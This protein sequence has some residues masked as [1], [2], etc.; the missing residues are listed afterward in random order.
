M[1]GE[2]SVSRIILSGLSSRPIRVLSSFCTNSLHSLI[3]GLIVSSLSFDN[4]HLL[5]CYVLFF[6]A[7]IQLVFRALF[8]IAIRKDSVSLLRYSHIYVHFFSCEISFVC[9]LI[10]PYS[11]FSSDF[12]FLAIFVLLIPD[13]SI[14]SGRFNLFSL[15][16]LCSLCVLVSMHQRYIQCRQV[17]LLLFF[18]HV[19]SF[20]VISGI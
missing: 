20:E 9:R 2:I 13:L 19:Q 6:F 5:I 12:Y 10:C 16:F 7:L 1:E 18:L 8:C 4:L 11:D 14:L 17:I 3:I 15:H